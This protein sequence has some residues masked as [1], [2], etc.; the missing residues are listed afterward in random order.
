MNP[1]EKDFPEYQKKLSCGL[2]TKE[3]L[4]KTKLSQ[5]K[6]TGEKAANIGPIY[7]IM[8]ICA[9]LKVFYASTTTK[10][11]FQHSSN[12]KMLTFYH[13]KGSDMLKLGFMF[14]NLANIC[15]N[16]STKAQLHPFNETD[17]DLLQKT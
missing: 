8:R 12:A 10:T 13:K 3:A 1:L 16:K 6:P 4:P 17:K 2:K 15:L 5:P 7:G 14:Q 9:P 11:L